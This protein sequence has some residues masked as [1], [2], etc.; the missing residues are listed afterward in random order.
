MRLFVQP[1]FLYSPSSTDTYN[2]VLGGINSVSREN[3][4]ETV[5][6]FIRLACAK[7]I[8]IEITPLIVPGLNDSVDELNACADFIVSL[9]GLIPWHLS[10]YHP[11]YRW[12]APP[13]D[14]GFLLQV[15]KQEKN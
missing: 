5:L 4:L 7:G 14:P 1:L 15:M 3:I 9:G 10:A 2:K 6:G 13:T 12:N 8:H 11:D